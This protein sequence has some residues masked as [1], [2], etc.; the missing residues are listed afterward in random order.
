M[1]WPE[2]S[3]HLT[4]PALEGRVFDHLVRTASPDC[5]FGGLNSLGWKELKGI[6]I[7]LTTSM[8]TSIKI[9][10]VTFTSSLSV[11]LHVQSV[12]AACAQTLY[13]LRVLRKHGLCDDSLHDI[14]RAVAVVKLVYASNAWWGFS[15]ANDRGYLL[16]FVA[17]FALVS[18]L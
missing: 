17:V 3:V 8:G 13:A 18:V 5:E 9:L 6:I 10:G 12:I 1:E 7:A 15:N 2:V 14:F 11:T 16:S 4:P